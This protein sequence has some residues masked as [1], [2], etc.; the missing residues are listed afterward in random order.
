M[1]IKNK[2]LITY[3]ISILFLFTVSEISNANPQVRQISTYSFLCILCG[4]LLSRISSVKP[5]KIATVTFVMFLYLALQAAHIFSSPLQYASV[6]RVLWGLILFVGFVVVQDSLDHHWDIPTWENA[7]ITVAVFVTLRELATAAVW[8]FQWH[9]ITGHF[10]PLP[11]VGYRSAGFLLGHPNILMGFVNLVLVIVFV[12]ALKTGSRRMR[13]I[14]ATI[15]ALFVLLAYFASSR[16]GWLS[17]VAGCAVSAAVAL[18]PAM[19]S[20]LKGA[21]GIAKRRIALRYLAGIGFSAVVIFSLTALFFIQS[22]S[23]PGH[24]TITTSRSKI[25][26]AAWNI[27][28]SSPIWGRGSSA[29][30]ILFARE[31]QIPPGFATSH[32]HNLVLQVAAENGIIGLLVAFAAFVLIVLAGY[33]YWREA[34][35]AG[36][37]DLAIYAGAAVALLVHQGF[38]Y[39]FESPLYTAAVLIILSLFYHR[40]SNAHKVLIPKR[41]GLIGLAA[42]MAISLFGSMLTFQN[43][44][45]YWDGVQAGKQ[46]D[47]QVAEEKIC[48]AEQLDPEIP[49]Y[50]FQCALAR[51]FLAYPSGDAVMFKKAITSIETGL[52][53]DPYWPTHWANLAALEWQIGDK[54]QALE[55]MRHAVEMAP[56][57]AELIVILG[58]MEE[59]MG[60]T[61]RAVERYELAVDLNPWLRYSILFD[62]ANPLH[63][64]FL[65]SLRSQIEPDP[66]LRALLE[67][68]Q[69][70][71]SGRAETAKL[72]FEQLIVNYPQEIRAYV[73]LAQAQ[74]QKGEF[75]EARENTIKALFLSPIGAIPPYVYHLA[76]R[77]VTAED[78]PADAMLHYEQA[79]WGALDQSNSGQYYD[80]TYL[81][82][83]LGPDLVPW[84]SKL[85]INRDEVGNLRLLAGVYESAGNEE[86]ADFLLSSLQY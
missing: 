3:L 39:L 51:A 13:V 76:G 65:T 24:G 37:Y 35:R 19:I 14:Y 53:R 38:D 56:R 15:I 75:A 60:E 71:Q 78:F 83:F 47:W 84:I 21:I 48:R 72:E 22:Q 42:L 16:G 52:L 40:V 36:R 45:L 74:I 63:E 86:L 58:W 31:N 55:N 49:L 12:R 29:F 23:V 18:G 27:F 2:R 62:P 41:P 4:V 5:F 9:H 70:L 64:N 34:D 17:A 57:N 61:R 59:Q 28:Q 50:H 6:E 79:F 43:T 20:K 25:W 80:R 69:D 82:T 44:T 8:L 7:L 73:G 30:P 11:P 32:A 68:W 1:T 10:L 85:R 46:R 81:R 26:G 33:Q 77:L 66:R 67:A 54:D